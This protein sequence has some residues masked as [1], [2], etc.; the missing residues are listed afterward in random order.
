MGNKERTDGQQRIGNLAKAAR[1]EQGWSMSFLLEKLRKAST[2]FKT[3]STAKISRIENGKATL[4]IDEA[5][6]YDTVLGKQ[7][8]YFLSN[9]PG[10]IPKESDPT[11]ELPQSLPM[12][13]RDLK[14]RLETLEFLEVPLVEI[15]T[16]PDKFAV[17]QAKGCIRVSK[18]DLAGLSDEVHKDL[19]AIRMSTGVA[20]EFGIKPQD[21]VVLNHKPKEVDGM[22]YMAFYHDLIIVRRMYW[23]GQKV[24]MEDASGKS[25]TV[26]RK[27]LSMS[28]AIILSGS[29]K[30]HWE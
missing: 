25:I 13:I 2:I 16:L 5:P 4:T 23:N 18:Q 11:R 29:W 6:I 7:L 28:G 12:L 17:Q 30:R 20:E 24:R 27:E 19:L 22:L 15:S 10:A 9:A 3:W 8:T 21:I 14:V 1:Q 26:N